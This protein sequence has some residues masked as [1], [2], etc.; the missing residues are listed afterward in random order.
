[1]AVDARDFSGE[2]WKLLEAHI[3]IPYEPEDISAGV[4]GQPGTFATSVCTL[5]ILVVALTWL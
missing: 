2:A 1:M 3:R 5:G 4:M